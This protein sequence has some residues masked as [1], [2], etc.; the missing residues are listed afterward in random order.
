MTSKA[1]P[2]RAHQMLFML[3]LHFISV[4]ICSVGDEPIPVEA[5]PTI[6]LIDVCRHPLTPSIYALLVLVTLHLFCFFILYH[7]S[8]G[9][10]QPLI[11]G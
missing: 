3:V 6:S 8:H 5:S 11:L 7:T 1:Q 10:T 9:L 4:V 2:S